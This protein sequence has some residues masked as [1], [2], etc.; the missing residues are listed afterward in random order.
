M[1][2][3]QEAGKVAG[4]ASS[5]V[6]KYLAEFPNHFSASATPKQGEKRILDIDDVAKLRYIYLSRKSGASDGEL[7]TG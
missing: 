7:I 2:T 4:V 6:R 1:F 3:S 5:T